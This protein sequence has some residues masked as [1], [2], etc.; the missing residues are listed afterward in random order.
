M[1]YAN[2]EEFIAKQ[3]AAILSNPECGTSH[4]NLA[5][6][7]LGIKQYEEAEKEL[8]EALLYSPTLAE[9]YVQL[10]GLCLMRGDLDGCLNY[11]KDATQVR[12]GF[13]IGYG[14]I[15]FVLFQKGNIEEAIVALEKAISYNS[16]FI[17]AYTTLA[18]AY[19]MKGMLDKSIELNLKTLDIEPNFAIAHNNLAIAYIEKQEYKNA[20]V[21]AD[22][23]S[24]LGYEIS[25]EILKE[26]EKY[27]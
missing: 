16:R 26:L 8:H 14:N 17:Q 22:K 24:Q 20:I 15:G 1:A 11:N 18:N 19:L 4:F 10:G 27:R 7:L 21:H 3:R 5:V 9:A 12:P 25:P 23:A 13:S 6:G 2:A